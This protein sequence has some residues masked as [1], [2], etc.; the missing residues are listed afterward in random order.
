MKTKRVNRYYCDYCK[1]SGCSSYWIREHEKHC[2]MNPKRD[3]RMCAIMQTAYDNEPQVEMGKLLACLDDVHY[4]ET[5]SV[6]AMLNISKLKETAQNCPAC[7]M[8]ALRQAGIPVSAAKDFNYKEM[9]E[10]IFGD[11]RQAQEVWEP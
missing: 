2:T 6:F 11:I 8:A 5:Q 7:I 10:S 1:K 9:G 4:D 3:C